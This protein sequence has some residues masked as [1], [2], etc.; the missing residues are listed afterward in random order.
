M[1]T[2]SFQP[3]W[4][5][6][7]EGVDAVIDRAARHDSPTLRR[8]AYTLIAHAATVIPNGDYLQRLRRSAEQ[9]QDPALIA[10]LQRELKR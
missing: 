4:D 7:A 9:E 6:Q 5:W 10:F 8:S 3:A 2:A 1:E